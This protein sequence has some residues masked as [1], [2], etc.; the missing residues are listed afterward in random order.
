MTEANPIPP[1][2]RANYLEREG[3]LKRHLARRLEKAD[4]AWGLPQLEAM[5]RAC[6]DEVQDLA[7]QADRFSPRHVPFDARGE[8]IDRVE[9]HES[10][11]RMEEIA[12]GS[13]AVALKYDARNRREHPLAL[14]AT[15]FAL[16]F[17]FG[18]AESGLFC[19]LCMTD[20]AAR[21]LEHAGGFEGDV[22]SL[23][24]TDARNARCTGAMFLT[25]KQ[26]GSDVGASS[27]VAKKTSAGEWRLTGQKWFCSNVDAERALALARPEGAA[28]GTRGLGL[29]L[30]R[31]EEP[32]R[33]ETV[34]IDRLKEK[35][36]VRSMPTGEVELKN[37][38]AQ[39]VGAVDQGFKQMAE[40]LNLSRLYNAVASAAGCGR[41][42][43]DAWS[44]ARG[45]RSFGKLVV[46]HTLA[47]ETL[48]E[49][50]AERAGA[51]LL[52]F[53]GVHALDR[54]DAAAY[55]GRKDEA[56]RKLLRGLT[57]LVKLFTAKV[58]VA[59]ASEAIEVW[60][61]NGYIEDS[62]LPRLLRDVQVLPIWEGTTN[63]LVLDLLRVARAE[64]AHEVLLAR[65]AE[66]LERSTLPSLGDAR[67]RVAALLGR[68]RAGFQELLRGNGDAPP[69]ARP[70][71]DN[72]AR[73]LETALLLEA[74]ETEGPDSPESDAAR[75]LSLKERAPAV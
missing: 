12:Y 15:G 73:A 9:Y 28:G 24:F 42:A 4:L 1:I 21:V 40:M 71:A 66:A 55:S 48:L 25:E 11:R 16:G 14:H 69:A 70:L 39:L 30:L 50:D 34:F 49:L 74:A 41:G 23:A 26:G 47:R 64:G 60:G 44:Y 72:T 38:R 36:G 56:A 22:R 33:H 67:D 13:G 32:D 31:R 43:I 53:E 6:G 59:C 35:L 7:W 3:F 45:R 37:A 52:A 10:Y 18:M 62:S 75:R 46:D 5:G 27:T 51:L 2:D 61:G 17:V 57:P 20:G 58:A 19:P 65:A 54:M 29:F 8:R 63:V 68:V